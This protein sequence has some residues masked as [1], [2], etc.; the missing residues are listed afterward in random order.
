V[1]RSTTGVFSGIGQMKGRSIWA[2]AQNLASGTYPKPPTL[3]INE[4]LV[5]KTLS[6][7]EALDRLTLAPT[8]RDTWM[9]E[10]EC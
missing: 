4:R 2:V 9:T 8:F 5:F 1:A 7:D 3:K 6:V 10:G